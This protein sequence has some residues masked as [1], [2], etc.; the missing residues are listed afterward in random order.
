VTST[1]SP[2]DG[3][4]TGAEP[5]RKVLC[6]EGA[7]TLGPATPR[8]CAAR[9]SAAS[10][11]SRATVSLLAAAP[12]SGRSPAPKVRRYP[13]IETATSRARWRVVHAMHCLDGA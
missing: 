2:V 1:S 10:V 11:L 12:P 13:G 9:S 7:S 5:L 3:V 4:G 6:F 8:A